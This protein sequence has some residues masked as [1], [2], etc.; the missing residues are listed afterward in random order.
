VGTDR[1]GGRELTE[2]LFG[3]YTGSFKRINITQVQ[4][5]ASD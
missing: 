4:R 5:T 2:S 3:P 1:A